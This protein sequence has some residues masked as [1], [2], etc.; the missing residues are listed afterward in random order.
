MKKLFLTLCFFVAC[1]FAYSQIM[2]NNVDINS[3]PE[4]R[5]IELSCAIKSAKGK[6]TYVVYVDYGQRWSVVTEALITDTNKTPAEFDGLM[7]VLN[8]FNKNGWK[9]VPVWVN[10]PGPGNK[11]FILQKKE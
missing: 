10:T 9:V 4:I 5:Y 11:S 1:S 3:V 7:S 8:Y 2:V 6:N